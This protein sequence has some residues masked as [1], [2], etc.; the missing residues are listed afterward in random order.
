MFRRRRTTIT[1]TTVLLGMC[2]IVVISSVIC[3]V[4][5]CVLEDPA[6]LRALAAIGTATAT[7]AA[8]ALAVA[9]VTHL[10][11]YSEVNERRRTSGG[12]RRLG[13]STRSHR[14]HSRMG[15]SAMSTSLGMRLIA[16][17]MPAHAGR[18]WLAEADGNLF[19]ITS[20]QQRAEAIRAYHSS[21][22][23]LIIASWTK[24]LSHQLR[25]VLTGQ[26]PSR[27][28]DDHPDTSQ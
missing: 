7:L 3:A 9:L 1:P 10:H 2:L 16:K 8:L 20:P 5:L 27:R 26:S 22:P 12:R 24:E 23:D 13:G 18:R 25:L 4:V 17:L 6:D 15:C 14:P 11:L 28:D 19:D 21:A